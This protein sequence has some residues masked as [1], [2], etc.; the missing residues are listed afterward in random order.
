MQKLII[1]LDKIISSFQQHT[2]Q[3]FALKQQLILII[4]KTGGSKW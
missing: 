3:N 4:G 2:K 1:F